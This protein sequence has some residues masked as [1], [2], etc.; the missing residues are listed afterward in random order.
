VLHAS[1]ARVDAARLL[2]SIAYSDSGRTTYVLEGT[3]N[4]AGSA[5]AWAGDALGIADIERQ[6]DDWL[7]RPIEPPLF[8]NG[9]SGLGAPY[10]VADFRS[11]FEGAGTAAERAVAV[12]ESIVFLLQVNLEEFARAGVRFAHAVAS[13]GLA[14]SA[15]LCQRLADLSG[16]PVTRPA[17]HEA[18]AKGLAFLLA[19]E[20]SDWPRPAATK[21]RP[22]PNP[23]LGERYRRWRTLMDAAVS[24]SA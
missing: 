8:L 18:T 14:Q 19:D 6:L 22:A 13:G 5:L 12:G 21:F 24:S 11:R 15:A 23:A 9:V 4:G 17:E 1:S 3:V 20:P 7:A 10:W 2:S 16:L